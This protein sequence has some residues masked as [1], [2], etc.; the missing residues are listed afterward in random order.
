MLWSRLSVRHMFRKAH[1]SWF[2]RLNKHIQAKSSSYPN[3]K[4]LDYVCLCLMA[5]VDWMIVPMR[6]YPRWPMA[7]ISTL[8]PMPDDANILDKNCPSVAGCLRI[9]RVSI[10]IGLFVPCINSRLNE[11][12]DVRLSAFLSCRQPF[13][14]SISGATSIHTGQKSE[15]EAI[16]LSRWRAVVSRFP[17]VIVFAA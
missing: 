3:G 5:L 13:R 7:G 9:S 8:M 10:E 15:G 6:N 14:T 1:T 11:Y 12:L 4:T 2:N 17:C 16:I